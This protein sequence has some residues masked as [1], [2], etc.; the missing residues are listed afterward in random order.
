[1]ITITRKKPTYES[2]IEKDGTPLTLIPASKNTFTD[3]METAASFSGNGSNQEKI[4]GM[5]RLL[6][7]IMNN[8]TAGI[9]VTAEELEEIDPVTAATIIKE[10][11][12]FMKG[13]HKDP[14]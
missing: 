5:Y 14:N 6:A 4:S 10:Y 11:T 9:A 1:M 13:L 8:N 12:A 2:G 3:I 7:V